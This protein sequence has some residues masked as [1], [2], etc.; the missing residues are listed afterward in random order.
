M[1]PPTSVFDLA[2]MRHLDLLA[3]W[4]RMHQDRR[5]DV[6]GLAS[7]MSKDWLVTAILQ[8]RAPRA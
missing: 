1:N 8:A 4:H 6:D 7:R 3:L 5:G 2:R